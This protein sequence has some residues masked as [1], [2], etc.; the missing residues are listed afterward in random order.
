MLKWHAVRLA[1]RMTAEGTKV[2]IQW[3]QKIIE[4]T[5]TIEPNN[6]ANQI[7]I[8]LIAKSLTSVQEERHIC[9]SCINALFI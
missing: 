4:L 1:P 9:V 8:D 7:K 2:T 5:K 6:S 3:H